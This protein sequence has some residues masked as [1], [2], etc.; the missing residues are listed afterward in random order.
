[1]K[2]GALSPEGIVNKLCDWFLCPH[3]IWNHNTM[4]FSWFYVFEV[5]TQHRKAASLNT[6][7]TRKENKMCTKRHQSCIDFRT[8]LSNWNK[9]KQNVLTNIWSFFFIMS[10]LKL[11]HHCEQLV[12]S[13][14]SLPLRFVLS[15][16][17]CPS[18]LWGKKK[19]ICF[20]L[21]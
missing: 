16:K 15:N 8:Q 21:T 11:S 5:V 3:S 20:T 2:Q 10:F 18:K 12:P 6:V 1:M 19:K 4:W 14:S 17:N 13:V 9:S 7:P